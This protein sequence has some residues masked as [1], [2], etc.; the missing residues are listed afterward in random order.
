MD[1]LTATNRIKQALSTKDFDASLTHYHLRNGRVFAANGSLTASCPITESLEHV[2]PAEELDKAFTIFGSDATFTWSEDTLVIK[3]NKKRMTIRLLKPDGVPLIEPTPKTYVVGPDFT[4]SM[5]KIRPFISDDAS[6]PWALTAWL[7]KGTHGFYVWTATNNIVVIEVD[8][9]EGFEQSGIDCQVPNF[10]L[11]FVLKREQRL[12]HFGH[13]ATKAS[14]FFDDESQLTTQLFSLK[15]PD[16]VSNMLHEQGCYDT[17]V[18]GFELTDSWKSAYKELVQLGAE[19]VV[20]GI[21]TMTAGKRQAT[22]EVDCETPAPFDSTKP[23]SCWNPKFLTPIT[24]LATHIDFS[25]Y[26]KAA[27]F[28]GPG[29]RGLIIGKIV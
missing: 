23:T 3:K 6:R 20:L 2:V 11:D 4:Q 26:P 8:A 21:S 13:D 5:R 14:F 18:V 7:H 22:L 25:A 1:L 15:M 9:S 17:N 10:A 24:E 28:F 29:L 12:T 19:E 27:K 16:M